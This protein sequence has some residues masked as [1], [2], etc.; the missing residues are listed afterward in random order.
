M[1]H[2]IFY[3]L[4][5]YMGKIP[6][7]SSTRPSSIIQLYI[8]KNSHCHPFIYWIV[9]TSF[10]TPCWGMT[11][12]LIQMPSIASCEPEH[13]LNFLPLN[14]VT[15]IVQYIVIFFRHIND[16]NGRKFQSL[17][18]EKKHP[19]SFLKYDL[20]WIIIKKIPS[21]GMTSLPVQFHPIML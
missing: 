14:H 21:Y 7:L 19:I 20:F 2:E 16:T 5:L 9:S 8:E 11:A 10:C 1:C 3:T 12:V 4:Y 18:L 13:N 6:S 15:S 17:N